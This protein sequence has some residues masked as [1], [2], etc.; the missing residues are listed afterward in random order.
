MRENLIH[1]HGDAC[2]REK[3]LSADGEG[4]Y[5]RSIRQRFCWVKETTMAKEKAKHDLT[6]WEIED[7]EACV[8]RQVRA[9]KGRKIPPKVLKQ[10][11]HELITK[12]ECTH[13]LDLMGL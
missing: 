12:G 7:T 9:L 11:H 6:K 3:G 13:P 5:E 4:V 8:R 1:D 2:H 10:L